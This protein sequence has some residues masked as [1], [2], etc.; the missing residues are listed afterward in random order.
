VN[1]DQ[2]P[3]IKTMYVLDI[4]TAAS[5]GTISPTCPGKTTWS[6]WKSIFR[7]MIWIVPSYIWIMMVPGCGNSGGE[8]GAPPVTEDTAGRTALSAGSSELGGGELVETMRGELVRY[9]DKMNALRERAR[10]EGKQKTFR[11]PEFNFDSKLSGAKALLFRV[12]SAGTENTP[13]VQALLRDDLASVEKDYAA[14]VASL[15]SRD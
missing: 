5:A 6:R 15:E 8:G 10:S 11:I 13:R 14:A 2:K 3:G 12:T 4:T 7:M 9:T 1:S